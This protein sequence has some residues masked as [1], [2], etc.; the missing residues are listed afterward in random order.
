MTEQPK[1]RNGRDWV[2]RRNDISSRRVYEDYNECVFLH[3][4][5]PSAYFVPTLVSPNYCPLPPYLGPRDGS[6]QELPCA[7]SVDTMPDDIRNID[8]IDRF[9]S[10][11]SSLSGYKG[12]SPIVTWTVSNGDCCFSA[13]NRRRRR[14]RRRRS[15]GDSLDE[16]GG[17][18]WG[19]SPR[20]DGRR[21]LRRS[22]TIWGRE[23]KG[24]GM[25]MMNGGVHGREGTI[26]GGE[27]GGYRLF[28]LPPSP[29]LPQR[30][31]SIGSD[32]NFETD[33]EDRGCIFDNKI[34][35][36]LTEIIFW[37]TLKYT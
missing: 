12:D 24:E 37:W 35:H 18:L 16:E 25:G 3:A 21:R 5:I 33:N 8:E 30:A 10:D 20:R 22:D 9:A 13:V 14:R 19:D 2:N 36:R 15:A 34:M 28:I 23:R 32:S 4:N 27:G 6:R 1:N 31:T 7:Y 29:R 11:V 17:R 26:A